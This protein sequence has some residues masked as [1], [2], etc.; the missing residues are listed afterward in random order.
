MGLK[1][2]KPFKAVRILELVAFYGWGSTASRLQSHYKE[3]VNFSLV[4]SQTFL[5]L[6]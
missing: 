5:V 3:A 6:I 4:I 2:V 1:L